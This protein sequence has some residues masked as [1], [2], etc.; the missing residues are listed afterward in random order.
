[1]VHS[2]ENTWH[3]KVQTVHVLPVKYTLFRG[4]AGW[5]LVL[6]WIKVITSPRLLA[7]LGLERYRYDVRDGRAVVVTSDNVRGVMAQVYPMTV[8]SLK[9]V[10][11]GVASLHTTDAQSQSAARARLGLPLVGRCVLFVGNDYGKKGLSTLIQALR[12]LPS[13]VYLTVV[14]NAAQIP[15]YRDEARACD[16][17]S[18]I[19]FLG[20]LNEVD[21]AYRAADCLAHPTLEDTFAMV[22]LEAMAFGLPVVVSGEKYCGISASLN[23]GKNALILE[24]PRDES[25]LTEAIN[26]IL[27]DVH[28]AR[29]LGVAA[30]EFAGRHL[31]SVV[32]RK[33][34]A[35]YA[36]VCDLRTQSTH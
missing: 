36:A 12:N 35:I 24:D 29:Q 7:Y 1:M 32:A 3:G 27:R 26:Y 17:A 28:V 22:V 19:H 21:I 10:T 34:E 14:G 33:Q 25:A 8:L 20:P 16:Q 23:N 30:E 15:K 2:H 9:V 6:R 11:P 18:R 4:I 13:D 31:W 5:R